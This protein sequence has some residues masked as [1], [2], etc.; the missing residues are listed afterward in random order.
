MGYAVVGLKTKVLERYPE[1]EKMKDI[2]R[3]TFDA[4]KKPLF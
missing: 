3:L 2:P 1:I 4:G